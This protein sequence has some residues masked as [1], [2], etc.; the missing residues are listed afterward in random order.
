MP[1][2]CDRIGGIAASPDVARTLLL[3]KSFGIDVFLVSD[4]YH[5]DRHQG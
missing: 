1:P 4:V 5:N 2:P 3:E